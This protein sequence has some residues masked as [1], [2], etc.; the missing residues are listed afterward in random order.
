MEPKY[1]QMKAKFLLNDFIGICKEPWKSNVSA[2]DFDFLMRLLFA[3]YINRKQLRD[4]LRKR[5]DGTS[6]VICQE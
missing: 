5:I 6:T 4:I 3:G 2:A 1:A